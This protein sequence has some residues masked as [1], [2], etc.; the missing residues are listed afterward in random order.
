MRACLKATDLHGKFYHSFD[1]FVFL[2]MKVC[3]EVA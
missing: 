2:V 3:G 1:L